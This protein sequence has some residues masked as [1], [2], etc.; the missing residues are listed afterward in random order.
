MQTLRGVQPLMEGWVY[1]VVDRPNV[2]NI[3]V[4]GHRLDTPAALPLVTASGVT[5]TDAIE[6][7]KSRAEEWDRE[8]R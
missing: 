8:N 1:Q 3:V 5:K 2:D 7:L 6:E 4:W